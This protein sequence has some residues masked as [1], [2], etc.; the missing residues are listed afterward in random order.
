M[1]ITTVGNTAEITINKD[2]E[3]PKIIAQVNDHGLGKTEGSIAVGTNR[4]KA[5]FTDISI[6]AMRVKKE[7][8]Q[9]DMKEMAVA[10][11]AVTDMEM[12]AVEVTVDTPDTPPVALGINGGMAPK[13]KVTD[14][15]VPIIAEDK[16]N[17]DEWSK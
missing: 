5:V 7:K 12:P 17:M 11:S 15:N 16:V 1:K 10:M 9:E 3:E 6:N 2:L 4:Q 14:S 8:Q 13:V